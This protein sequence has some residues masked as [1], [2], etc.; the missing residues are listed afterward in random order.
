M[1]VHPTL[2]SSS[3]Q[4]QG[5]LTATEISAWTEQAAESLQNLQLSSATR[6]ADRHTSSG[7]SPR[8]VSSTLVIP[9]DG[10]HRQAEHTPAPLRLKNV[11]LQDADEQE[12]VR[13]TYRRGEP[14]RRDSLKRR[15]ALLKGK[16]GSR[17]RQRWENGMS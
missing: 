11:R 3:A 7:S 4:R 15:E 10:D 13:L 6:R 5:Q 14:I 8:P 16:E 12:P 1:A 9:L 17:R 2:E